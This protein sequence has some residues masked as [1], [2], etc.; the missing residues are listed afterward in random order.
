MSPRHCGP[1]TYP[2]TARAHTGRARRASRSDGEQPRPAGARRDGHPRVARPIAPAAGDAANEAEAASPE[3]G[4]LDM[5]CI[6]KRRGKWVVDYRDAAGVRRWVTCRTHRDAEAVLEKALRES[7][8][9][10]IPV[11]DPDIT[12][13]AYSERWLGVI[14]VSLKPRTVET[15]SDAL[16]LHLLPLLGAVKVRPAS[17]RAN[18]SPASQEAHRRPVPRHRAYSACHD[19]SDAQR[20]AGGW[21]DRCAPR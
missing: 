8:N 18:Q 1:A 5:A 4:A 10:I 13:K 7:R 12:I 2:A 21:R 15:Y 3:P 6:R 16:R 11:V 17:P 19:P 14:P 20:G 9:P